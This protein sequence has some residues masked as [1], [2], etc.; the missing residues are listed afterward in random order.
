[1]LESMF[2]TKIYVVP[3]VP[4]LRG[5]YTEVV[6]EIEA[7][8]EDLGHSA[9]PRIPPPAS[10]GCEKVGRTCLGDELSEMSPMNLVLPGYQNAK[11]LWTVWQDN[12]LLRTT[13]YGRL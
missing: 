5:G 3:P 11:L 10:V 8:D 12:D 4:A 13:C 2:A 6:H 1:M 7:H 9:R